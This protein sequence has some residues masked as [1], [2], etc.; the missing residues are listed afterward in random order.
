MQKHCRPKRPR[1]AGGQWLP[2]SYYQPGAVTPEWRIQNDA[3]V[4]YSY[5]RFQ[6]M[7]GE[8]YGIRWLTHFF[9]APAPPPGADRSSS[10]SLTKP[11]FK[12]LGREEHPFGS[13]GAR[14]YQV[15]FIEPQRFLAQLMRDIQ[16][17]GGKIVGRSFASPAAVAALPE[18]LV[19][20]CT[21][22]GARALFGDKDLYPI[23]GQL[24]VLLPQPEVN[25][26]FGGP[27]GYMF[28]RSDGIILGGTY[29][30]NEW[31]TAPDPATTDTL[32][33]AHQKVFE[34]LRCTPPARA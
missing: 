28:P 31:S 16:I 12:W 5:R 18:S 32:L 33:A 30:R 7:V 13:E 17:A 26:A 19:F 34:N 1:I 21:G 29:E 4:D 6:I 15:M 11:G 2:S 3:A 27:S 22:L 8:D 23:R 25:Y 9:E 10:G 20:N 14:Q 24:V